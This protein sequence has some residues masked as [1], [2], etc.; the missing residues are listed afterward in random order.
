[1]PYVAV[2]ESCRFD[3]GLVVVAASLLG[4]NTEFVFYIGIVKEDVKF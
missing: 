4:D 3:T 1:M 2:T